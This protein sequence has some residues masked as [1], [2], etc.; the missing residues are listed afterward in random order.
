MIDEQVTEGGLAAR[1]ASDPAT[2]GPWDPGLQHGG[3]PSALLT[4]AA[5]VLTAARPSGPGS[6]ARSDAA[7][8]FV[9]MRLAV[10]FVG[11]VPVDELSVEARVVRA[12]RSAVLV[13]ATVSARGR[14]CLHGRVW[15][16]RATDTA[17][18][19]APAIA[20]S[21]QPGALPGI[22]AD[23][24]YGHSIEWQSVHGGMRTPGPGITWARPRHDLVPGEALSGLQRV[25]LV[26]DSASGV[27]AELDWDEWSFVN[28]DLDVHLARPVIGEWVLLDAATTLGT[29][30]AAL[31]RS[32]VSDRHGVAGCTAQ[33]LVLGRRNP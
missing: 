16:V 22:G 28:I 5:E 29:D 31:A 11:P 12:A 8:R 6:G 7:A 13:D 15:L 20:P 4:R 2:G 17:G 14:L 21:V 10:E 9:A 30:G 26:G 32:T 23:F 19:A 3:P 33:T 18:I 27:S 25:V 24:P 1:Y